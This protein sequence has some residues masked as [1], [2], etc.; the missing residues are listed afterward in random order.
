MDFMKEAAFD[1]EQ[2]NNCIKRLRYDDRDVIMYEDMLRFLWTYI[3][4]PDNITDREG[5]LEEYTYWNLQMIDKCYCHLPHDLPYVNIRR[6]YQSVIHLLDGDL[7]AG[8]WQLEQIGKEAFMQ[9]GRPPKLHMTKQG[10]V[11]RPTSRLFLI[12]NYDKVIRM[13][14]QRLAERFREDYPFAFRSFGDGNHEEHDL[15]LK[16]QI[17]LHSGEI[18]YP[19]FERIYKLQGGPREFYLYFDE[20][21]G[22]PLEQLAG[23]QSRRSPEAVVGYD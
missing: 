22:I 20:E 12:Y 8:L 7:D 9:D 17:E 18:F 13:R 11:Y 21:K 23:Y 3:I 6:A 15:F 10:K 19:E 1:G 16:S 2:Y 5:L 14:H 4:R